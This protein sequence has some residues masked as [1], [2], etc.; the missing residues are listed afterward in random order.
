MPESSTR[1]G[2]IL[3]TSSMT[4]A[5]IM[6]TDVVTIE[7]NATASFASSQMKRHNSAHL[8]VMENERLHGV[9]SERDVR[10]PAAAGIPARRIVQDL[11]MANTISIDPATTLRQ[12]ANI[13][14]ERQLGIL[15]VFDRSRLVGIVTA[16]EVL[17]ELG[18][19]PSRAPLPGWLPKASKRDRGR[20]GENP[21]PAHIRVLGASVSKAKRDEIRRKL[22]NKLG[23]FGEDIERVTVRFKDVNGPRGGIDQVC[24]I[25]VVL[26][27]LPSVV[28]E[29]R[30]HSP[31]AAVQAALA[32][33]ERAV[34]RR[35]QRSRTKPTQKHAR[36]TSVSAS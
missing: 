6:N 26:S 7:P 35:L 8:V 1:K 27:N 17:D 22:G 5:E 23:K 28:F 4:V 33:T 12:A 16:T 14:V 11:M 10:D 24:R 18:R 32:G 31:D 29:S 2:P 30:H 15:P 21:I 36:A 34:R 19:S 25:K 20:N 13:M 9:V 3:K